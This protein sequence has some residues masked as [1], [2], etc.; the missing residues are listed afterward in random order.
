MKFVGAFL[1]VSGWLLI[2][3]SLSILRTGAAR[4]AFILAGL[5]VEAAGLAIA[6]R[7]HLPERADR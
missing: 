1:L 6:I 4:N 2:L 7:A 3:C 5:V